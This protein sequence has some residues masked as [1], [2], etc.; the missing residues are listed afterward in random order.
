MLKMCRFGGSSQRESHYLD[1][2][3]QLLR[4]RPRFRPG[5]PCTSAHRTVHRTV[6]RTERLDGVGERGDEATAPL[7][8]TGRDATGGGSLGW[9][10]FIVGGPRDPDEGRSRDDDDDGEEHLAEWPW[11]SNPH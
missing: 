11:D 10:D 3:G 9:G 2:L 5:S 7:L 8:G 6:H 4:P 1:L